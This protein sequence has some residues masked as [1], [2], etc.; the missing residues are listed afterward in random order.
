MDVV[1]D[2]EK[3]SHRHGQLQNNGIC[4]ALDVA[5][6]ESFLASCCRL[7]EKQEKNDLNKNGGNT[8]KK[9]IG[10]LRERTMSRQ[11]FQSRSPSTAGLPCVCVCFFRDDLD[12]I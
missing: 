2:D 10:T 9:E 1:D 6:F 8:E 11:C 5:I 3:E 4:I 7:A 12:K